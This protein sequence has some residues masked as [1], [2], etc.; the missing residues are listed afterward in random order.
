MNKKNFFGL[1]VVM[2]KD[3]VGWVCDLFEEEE[4]KCEFKMLFW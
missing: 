4:E 3:W 1:V 2:F